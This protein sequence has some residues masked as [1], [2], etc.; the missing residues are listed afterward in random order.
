VEGDRK[1]FRL[2]RFPNQE[3]VCFVVFHQKYSGSNAGRRF[4]K[5]G[6]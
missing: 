3:H 4:L 1:L 2:D 5:R 6:A